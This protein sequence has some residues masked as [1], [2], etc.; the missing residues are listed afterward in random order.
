[1]AEHS[2]SEEFFFSDFPINIPQ[3]IMAEGRETRRA[4]WYVIGFSS[5]WKRVR[6]QSSA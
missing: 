4:S 5:Y 6:W 1:M 3:N 2:A